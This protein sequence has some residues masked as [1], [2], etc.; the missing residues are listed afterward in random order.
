MK[1]PEKGNQEVD[2][3]YPNHQLWFKIDVEKCLKKP[4]LKIRATLSCLYVTHLQKDL[5]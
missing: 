5:V 2:C 1:S 3:D 4:A